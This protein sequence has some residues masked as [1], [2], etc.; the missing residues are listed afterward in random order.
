VAP[1][2]PYVNIIQLKRYI[3]DNTQ[4]YKMKHHHLL[5]IQVSHTDRFFLH[6]IPNYSRH[7][8]NSLDRQSVELLQITLIKDDC[9][10]NLNLPIR[11]NNSPMKP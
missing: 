10:S 9:S 11:G 3:P 6:I 1:F 8:Y 4:R 7:Q 2:S 5:L